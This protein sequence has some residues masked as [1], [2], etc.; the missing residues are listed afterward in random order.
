MRIKLRALLRQVLE[1][2]SYRAHIKF[3]DLIHKC[4]QFD[5]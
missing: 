4:G 3:Q 1:Q 2:F 5:K